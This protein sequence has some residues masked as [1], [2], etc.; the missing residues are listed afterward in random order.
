[1]KNTQLL[2]YEYTSSVSCNSN[3]IYNIIRQND[4]YEHINL[5]SWKLL[6]DMK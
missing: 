5:G 4:Q 1:M 3:N 2:K 6:Y